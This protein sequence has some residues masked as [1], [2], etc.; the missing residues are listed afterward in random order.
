MSCARS[1]NFSA[2]MLIDNEA[3][4]DH[5]DPKTGMT[6]II[7][8]AA[9]NNLNMVE[10]L[11]DEGAF[12]TKQD[13]GGFTALHHAAY[14]AHVSMVYLLLDNDHEIIAHTAGKMRKNRNSIYCTQH[15]KK[16][17]FSL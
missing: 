2:N 11:I 10:R 9:A 1:D 8:C 12:L 14:E 13:K 16:S 17:Q 4:V 7:L 6:P 5:V 15:S 3:D